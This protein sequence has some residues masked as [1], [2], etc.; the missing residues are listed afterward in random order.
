[1]AKKYKTKFTI[2]EIVKFVKDESKNETIEGQ[3]IKKQLAREL[4]KQLGEPKQEDFSDI[5]ETAGWG[6]K[7]I[8]GY[9]NEIDV[10]TARWME[11]QNNQG[12]HWCVERPSRTKID[13]VDDYT[14]K[15]WHCT[16]QAYN[17]LCNKYVRHPKYEGVWVRFY[18]SRDCNK[19]EYIIER[20]ENE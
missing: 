2:D 6:W 16:V 15:G 9:T 5:Y 17:V 10:E 8:Q 4:Y 7:K 20:D 3:L 12:T 1:M 14:R 13:I 11:G 19:Y 18:S